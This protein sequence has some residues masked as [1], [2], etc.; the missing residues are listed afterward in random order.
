MD[1]T[2]DGIVLSTRR[3]GE[4]SAILVLLTREHGRHAGLVQG[5]A[6]TRAQALLQPGNRVAA[7]WRGRL[8]EH[9]GQYRCELVEAVAARYL[10]DPLR[11]AGLAAAC[12]VADQTLPE[13]EPHPAAFEGL[14]A[15][16]ELL[17]SPAWA[18]AYVQW[19]LSLLAEL[20][21][22]LDLSRC[23]LT[24]G[25][26]QLAYVSPRSGRAVSLSAAEPWRDR[27]LPLPGFLA[28]RGGGGAE[29]ILQG[30][31]LTGHFLDAHLFAP[32]D[33]PLP[34]PRGLLIDRLRRNATIC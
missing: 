31:A 27:L 8:A 19:E 15:L 13:R 26:D 18:A 14:A 22:G 9:L 10:D 4:T 1:W 34:E 2:D 23:A 7:T 3:H 25:N 16:L 28:G 6:G 20:G 30:L 11:L 17:D 12:A 32:H 21:F 29:E 33:R 5:G 24:G